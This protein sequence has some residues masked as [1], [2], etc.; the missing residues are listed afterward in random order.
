MTTAS[1]PAELMTVRAAAVVLDVDVQTVRRLI[2][3]GTLTK[4][5]LRR[6]VRVRVSQVLALA[7]GAPA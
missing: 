4:V 1:P 5:P 7:Q 3:D 2:A 6:A